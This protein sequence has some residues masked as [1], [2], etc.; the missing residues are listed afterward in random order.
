MAG[1]DSV[2]QQLIGDDFARKDA[3]SMNVEFIKLNILR[4]HAGVDCSG[5][6]GHESSGKDDTA[7]RSCNI[8]HFSGQL[9]SLIYYILSTW[10]SCLFYYY[11]S[12]I[13]NGV[14]CTMTFTALVLSINE[15]ASY[16]VV[17]KYVS[18]KIDGN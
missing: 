13:V 8:V 6:R 7:K 12:H 1:S 16:F 9:I 5:Q 11:L 10:S 3:F 17:G 18:V 14:P 4:S 15:I 2:E